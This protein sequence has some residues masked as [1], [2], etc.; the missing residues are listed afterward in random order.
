MPPRK[1]SKRS[2]NQRVRLDVIPT[3]PYLQ[4]FVAL[5]DAIQQI[6]V[7]KLRLLVNNPAHPSLQAHRL[8]ST[9][10]QWCCYITHRV[11]LR[12]RRQRHRCWL[13]DVGFH[14]IVDRFP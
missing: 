4:A 11:R 7:N 6:V 1:R 8:H 10:D 2:E 9:T 12:Y 5:P 13:L 3:E 14:R